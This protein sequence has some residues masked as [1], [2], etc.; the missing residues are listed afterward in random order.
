[1]M[2]KKP[3][4]VTKTTKSFPPTSKGLSSPQASLL[5]HTIYRNVSACCRSFMRRVQNEILAPLYIVYATSVVAAVVA[6]QDR[7]KM[8]GRNLSLAK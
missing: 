1:M 7:E 6:L 3:I 8:R 4:P 5:A 2:T